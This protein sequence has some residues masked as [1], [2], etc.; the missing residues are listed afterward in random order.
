[1]LFL[2]ALIATLLTTLGILSIPLLIWSFRGRQV[3]D[4]PYCRRC[5]FD[6]FGRP[7]TSPQC[8][9]CGAELD[10]TKAIRSGRRE[11][12]RWPLALGAMLFALMAGYW[13]NYAVQRATHLGA[14]DKPTWWLL[15][16]ADSKNAAYS[17][18]AL[19][20]LVK[21]HRQ[22]MLTVSQCR[23][24][25]TMLL[26]VQAKPTATWNGQYGMAI[27]R[28]RAEGALTDEQWKEYWIHAWPWTLRV[29]QTV[30]RGDP[31]PTVIEGRNSVF[32]GRYSGRFTSGGYSVATMDIEGIKCPTPEFRKDW[33]ESH[34]GTSGAGSGD[35]ITR[36]PPE[37]MDRLKYGPNKITVWLDY[38]VIDPGDKKREL[39]RTRFPLTATFQLVLPGMETVTMVVKPD[40][41][42]AMKAA[43]SDAVVCIPQSTREDV[44]VNIRPSATPL[45]VAAKVF[46]RKSSHD[47]PA[48]NFST[49]IGKGVRV[50]GPLQSEEARQERI[51]VVLKPDPDQALL[52]PD[53]TEIWGEEIILENVLVRRM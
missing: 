49:F 50:L 41:R 12:R 4:H 42:A 10:R 53:V 28:A 23:K 30:R 6:L 14:A 36:L 7:P 21:R 38:V 32:G 31:V 33:I 47:Q 20:E 45:P 16:D 17:Q 29:R 46:L 26:A 40:C 13:G 27:E 52:S 43:F 34:R 19:G 25:M 22:Q 1:M 48:G 51:T 15:R 3:C 2:S 37:V 24:L 35:G 18:A 8:S 11:R 9:E 44:F 5:G 39:I